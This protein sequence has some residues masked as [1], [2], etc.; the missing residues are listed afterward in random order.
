MRRSN[1][2]AT[3]PVC[4][5]SWHITILLGNQS[6]AAF[7]R[8]CHRLDAPF[9]A[10]TVSST[11]TASSAGKERET[12]GCLDSLLHPDSQFLSRIR[13]E[14]WVETTRTS[15][16]PSALPLSI[17]VGQSLCN[18]NLKKVRECW[19][20]T[21]HTG[22]FVISNPTLFL[23]LKLLLLLLTPEVSV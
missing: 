22:H 23:R 3:Y 13:A 1:L 15:Q 8:Q 21:S 20:Q 17:P 6:V 5:I 12:V 4:L 2:R 7:M 11:K 9:A 19:P 14:N 16:S 18:K 10:Y